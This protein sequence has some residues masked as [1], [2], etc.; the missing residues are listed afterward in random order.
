MLPPSYEIFISSFEKILERIK[1]KENIEP[2]RIVLNDKFG[3]R[4]IGFLTHLDLDN[5][6][7]VLYSKE[8]F[9][10]YIQIE[11]IASIG[12]LNAKTKLNLLEINN[13]KTNSFDSKSERAISLDEKSEMIEEAIQKNL[14]VKI[15]FIPPNIEMYDSVMIDNVL[16]LIDSTFDSLMEIAYDEFGKNLVS[17]VDAIEFVNVDNNFL[18]LTKTNNR[19][20]LKYCLSKSLPNDYNSLIKNKLEKTL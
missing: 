4:Y 1:Q 13:K 16:S 5:R 15:K 6:V 11:N 12:L 19:I 7:L 10:T 14:G 9:I 17:K 2:P 18:S 3:H 8:D 20:T